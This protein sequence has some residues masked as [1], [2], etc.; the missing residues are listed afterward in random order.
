VVDL[1]SLPK[2]R[3]VSM[4]EAGGR[5]IDCYRAL[6]KSDA[7]VVAE[8][9]RGQGEFYEWDHYPKGDVY[10]GDSHSQYYYHAHPA[11]TRLAAYGREHGHFHTFVRAEGMPAGVKPAAVPDPQPAA[12][13]DG[14]PC[15]LIGI[16]MD[17][18]G[19]PVRL[20]TTNR[21]VTGETWY[22]AAD[23]V[24]ILD[25]FEIDLALPS[26]P[27]NVWIGCMLRLFRPDIE[28]LVRERDRAVADRRAR[29]GG[30]DPLEDRG[31]EVASVQPISVADRIERLQRELE[32]RGA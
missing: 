26:W 7:N 22:E 11:E 6:K 24:R 18:A 2:E 10:D 12:G 30:R 15:H 1:A 4:A 5:I 29:P 19:F 20:F 28:E 13:A 31:L 25:R 3:L 14:A 27:V 16:S 8:V 9:L 21:W 17:R 32:L 23:V